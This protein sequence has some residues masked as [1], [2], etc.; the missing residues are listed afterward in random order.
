[1]N[2]CGYES[3]AH[4]KLALLHFSVIVRVLE[5]Y[6]SVSFLQLIVK[7]LAL[8]ILVRCATFLIIITE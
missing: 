7:L 5:N 3:I 8:F 2:N 4:E 1:M 6:A